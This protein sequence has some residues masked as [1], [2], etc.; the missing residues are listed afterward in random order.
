MRRCQ[1]CG[2]TKDSKPYFEKPCT[3]SYC[4]EQGINPSAPDQVFLRMRK[5]YEAQQW[6]RPKGWRVHVFYNL[7]WHACLR[8]PDRCSVWPSGVAGGFHVTG[9]FSGAGRTIKEALQD[10]ARSAER[11]VARQAKAAKVYADAAESI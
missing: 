4:Q 9:T 5:R 7:G 8:G 6:A 11:E 3:A 10:A 1:S 2:R